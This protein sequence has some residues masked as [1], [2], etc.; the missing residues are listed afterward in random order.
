MSQSANKQKAGAVNA[1]AIAEHATIIAEQQQIIEQQ[2]K[3]IEEIKLLLQQQASLSASSSSSSNLSLTPAL[4]AALRPKAPLAP[5]ESWR[6]SVGHGIARW[7]DSLEGQHKYYDRTD[8]E[9][10][11]TVVALLLDPALSEYRAEVKTAGE[12]K[13]YEELCS[14]L[15]KRWSFVEES[16]HVR[17]QLKALVAKG[18]AMMPARYVESFRQLSVK[19]DKDP[20]EALIFDFIEGLRPTFRQ[21]VHNKAYT[22]LQDAMT[23]VCRMDANSAALGLA[24]SH[25]TSTASSSNDSDVD[26][27]ALGYLDPADRAAC[28]AALQSEGLKEFDTS[29]SPSNST[30]SGISTYLQQQV[31]TAVQ[32]QLAAAGLIGGSSKPFKKA[33]SSNKGRDT[34]RASSSPLSEIPLPIRKLREAYGVCL[35]CGV[36]KF[37][38][39][40]DGHNARTCKAPL[41]KKTVPTGPLPNLQ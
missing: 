32:L 37:S 34:A 2:Q 22:N 7:L 20:Q 14:R 28:I 19:L 39:G 15:L 16:F 31:A 10:R 25:T 23:H 29:G 1:A 33:S 36:H 4:L 38:A 9:K 21:A 41:D 5:P 40:A 30:S 12:P 8:E 24:T 26:L 35:R 17:K 27:S 3:E 11:A 18:P 13:D 6:G